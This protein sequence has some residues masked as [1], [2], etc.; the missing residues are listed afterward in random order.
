MKPPVRWKRKLLVALLALFI[1]WQFLPGPAEN[2]ATTPQ[3]YSIHSSRYMPHTVA[4][5]I[6]AACTDCHSNNTRYPWYTSIQPIAWYTARHIK[7]GKEELNLDEL[8]SYSLKKQI[9][10]LESI[11]EQLNGNTMPPASYTL[12]HREARLTGDQ[13]TMIAQW[14]DSLAKVMDTLE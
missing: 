9:S 5:L 6:Q 2:T 3:P 12:L 11:G 14:A 7:K 13:R 4:S 10:K 1:T 8:L